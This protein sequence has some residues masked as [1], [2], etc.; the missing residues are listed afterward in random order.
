MRRCRSLKHWRLETKRFVKDKAVIDRRRRD[1]LAEALRHFAAGL[2]TNDEYEERVDRTFEGMGPSRKEDL[3][4][5]A[6][7]NRAWFLYDDLRT[8]RLTGQWA[9]TAEGR[10]EI[11]RWVMFL[12]T[13]QEYK[14]PITN[15]I[16]PTGCLLNMVTLGLWGWIMGPRRAQQ[17]E[18]MG[19]WNIWPF[20]SSQSYEASRR[21]PRLLCRH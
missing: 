9:L 16:N 17:L 19:D 2:L 8:H 3:A 20:L 12:Y 11:A 7:Y 6:V 21:N 15:F 18:A 10:S 4:L 13:D 14:W 1:R 5:W